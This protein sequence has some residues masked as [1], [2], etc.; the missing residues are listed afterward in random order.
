[1]LLKTGSHFNLHQ[2]FNYKKNR[3]YS[4]KKQKVLKTKFD[5]SSNIDLIETVF[6]LR[7]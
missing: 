6:I 3:L 5:K 1:M 2:L 7:G 4:D